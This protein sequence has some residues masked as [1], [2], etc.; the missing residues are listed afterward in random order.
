MRRMTGFTLFELLFVLVI[1]AVLTAVAV[2]GLRGFSGG[3]DLKHIT[4]TLYADL[5]YA[6]SEAVKRNADVTLTA[7]G[8]TW[9]DGWLVTDGA[10]TAID[11][12]QSA[13]EADV[14]RAGCDA[15]NSGV[16]FETVPAGAITFAG[17]GRAGGNAR[18]VLCDADRLHAR[19][20]R[21]GVDG[22]PEI[23]RLDACP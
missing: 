3:Q 11:C 10:A 15:A 4:Q 17:N 13:L 14:L 7:N 16:R 9:G 1:V 5:V 8:G 22:L 20:V 12:D 23:R 2:P 19:E 21:V 18:F 6:R